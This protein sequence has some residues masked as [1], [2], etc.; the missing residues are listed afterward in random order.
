VHQEEAMSPT[1]PPSADEAEANERLAWH[2]LVLHSLEEAADQRLETGIARPESDLAKDDEATAPYQTSH[3]VAHS[4]A[5]ASDA[6]R[7]ARMLLDD[8][9]SIRVPWIGLY[10]VLRTVMEASALATWLLA[11][12]ER[13][14]RIERTLGTRWSDI[15]HDDQAVIVS[16]TSEPSDDARTRA[17]KSKLLRENARFI[18]DK[19]RKLRDHARQCDVELDLRNGRPGFGPILEA[20]AVE[21]DMPR[22]QVRGVWHFVSGLA[23]PSLSRSLTMSAL[24]IVG[25]NEDGTMN[26]HMSANL[27]SVT[28]AI[29]AAVLGYK[30]A[31][32]LIET[33]GGYNDIAWRP[34][35]S[36]PL[37]PRYQ[38]VHS[39]RASGS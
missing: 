18:R 28:M 21:I 29:D 25:R 26:A 20:A 30:T 24:Q 8:Q 4:V 10:P 7:T 17:A 13:A 23:H 5:V 11:P 33:R 27:N 38:R 31:L 32:D 36:F 35:T 16:M 19:K 39:N 2:I 9:G 3:L 22:G 6:L 15:I 14:T 1:F 34:G 37:P 12:S